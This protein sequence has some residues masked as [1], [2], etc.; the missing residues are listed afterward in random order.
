MLKI[1]WSP[2]GMNRQNSHFLFVHLLLL[3]RSLVVKLG[4]IRRRSR[5]LTRSHS[6]SSGDSTTGLL[7]AVLRRSLAPS[8]NL[9][10]I[11]YKDIINNSFFH[12]VVFSRKRLYLGPRGKE[13]ELFKILVWTVFEIK[14]SSKDKCFEEN[15]QF[16][17]KSAR[18]KI[19]GC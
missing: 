13:R 6:L 12:Y 11:T 15:R 19:R 2:T 4:V 17:Y 8:S 18:R 16:L 5:S 10:Q 7:T 3:Q 14:I 9:P 1:S